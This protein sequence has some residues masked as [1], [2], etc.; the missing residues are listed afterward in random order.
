MVGVPL[1]RDRPALDRILAEEFGLSVW[2]RPAA[3]RDAWL[4]NVPGLISASGY[5]ITESHVSVSGRSGER[6]LPSDYVII[7]LWAYR[8]GR[9]QLVR[10]LSE[11]SRQP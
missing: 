9:W 4:G 11:A 5:R 1:H 2:D 10:R 3:P 8:A 7:D 6:I